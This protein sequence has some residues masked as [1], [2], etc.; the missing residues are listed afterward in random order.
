MKTCSLCTEKLGSKN[1]SGLCRSHYKIAWKTLNAQHERENC[2]RYY[3]QNQEHVRRQVKQ[4]YE[5]IKGTEEFRADQRYREALHRARLL[6][7]TPAWTD[8]QKIKE[9]YARCPAGYHVDHIHPL[10]GE[11]VCGLHVP[12]NLQYLPALDNI[13]K[14]NKLMVG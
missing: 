12:E 5:A 8:L 7:A 3:A 4:R 1:K 11:Y 14:S 9:I 10:N 6:Q 2:K 13:K